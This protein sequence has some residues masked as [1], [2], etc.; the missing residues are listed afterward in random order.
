MKLKRRYVLISYDP[1][2]ILNEN[3]VMAI[4]R[5][6]LFS[7]IGNEYRQHMFIKKFSNN[8]LILKIPIFI[9]QKMKLIFSEPLKINGNEVV[10]EILLVSGTIKGINRKFLTKYPKITNQQ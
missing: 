3:D 8:V 10:I 1:L 2:N 5:N 7:L 4:I 9:F 6:Q